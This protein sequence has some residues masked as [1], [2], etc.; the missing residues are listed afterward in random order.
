MKLFL[1]FYVTNQTLTLVSSDKSK[2]SNS[3]SYLVIY[4]YLIYMGT[5]GYGFSRALTLKSFP[6]QLTAFVSSKHVSG[7]QQSKIQIIANM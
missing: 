3:C 4:I 2:K 7:N 5:Y 1:L 6:G